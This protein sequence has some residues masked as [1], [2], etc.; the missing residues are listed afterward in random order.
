MIARLIFSLTLASSLPLLGNGGGYFRGG[1]RSTGDIELFEPEEVE[2][3][4]ML[5][6]K[7]TI[8]LGTKEAKVEIRYLLKNE[9]TGKVRVRFG[10]PVE[11]L[12]DDYMGMRPPNPDDGKD[13]KLKYCND[14]KITAGGKDL[15]GKWKAESSKDES[16]KI[17]GIAGWLVSELGFEPG[18][19]KPVMISFTS[20]YPA[21]NSFVSERTFDSASIFKYRLS[22]AACWAGTIGTGKIVVRPAGAAADEIKVLKPVN[23]FKK[24]GSSWVWDFENLEPTMADDLEIEAVP[25]TRGYGAGV[26]VDSGSWAH[27]ANRGGKWTMQHANYQV[28]ASSTLPPEGEHRYDA[29]LLKDTYQK[30]A[31]SEG[32][33]GPGI[34]EWLELKPAV[35]KPVV[36]IGITPGFATSDELFKANNRPRRILVNLNGEHEFTADIPDSRDYCRV[37]VNAYSKPVKSIRITFKDVWKGEQFDDLC[38]TQ[39]LLESKLDKAP[40]IEPSR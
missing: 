4:R 10:F 25:E 13:G 18:E 22:S 9:T 23:R 1:I 17:K 3:I 31:W 33:E 27:Y 11:E 19:E 34:G 5:D 16:K 6:E 21:S 39:I 15:T 8:D 30:G 37:P 35:A 28:S 26:P 14:Y 29:S 38:V 2:K 12:F 20:G 24:E 32:A 36:A 40:K 7:L